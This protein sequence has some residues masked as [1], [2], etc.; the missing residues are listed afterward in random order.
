MQNT[1]SKKKHLDAP[2]IAISGDLACF[3]QIAEYQYV[4]KF[5]RVLEDELHPFGIIYCPGNHDL[6]WSE[7]NGTCKSDYMESL[8]ESP[9]SKTV[10]QIESRFQRPLERRNFKVGMDN[11]Y[12]FLAKI[13][14]HYNNDFLYSIKRFDFNGFPVNFVSLNSAYMFSKDC[15]DFGYIGLTQME[16]AFEELQLTSNGHQS[17]NVALF[18]HPFESIVPASEVETE[19]FL[20]R[21][22]AL[23]LNGHV[24]NL[25]VYYDLTT[26]L[27]GE[28]W[29]RPLISCA[30]CAIDTDKDPYITPGY[31]ILRVDLA[32][33]GVNSIAIY[34]R[35]NH[36][37]EWRE[38]EQVDYPIRVS[39]FSVSPQPKVLN[40]E[41]DMYKEGIR[42]ANSQA[43]QNLIVYQRT[44]S[45]L[46]GAKPYD[47][48]EKDQFELDYI[49][50]LR[51][52][53]ALCV[54]KTG[55]S[56]LYLFDLEKTRKIIKE[57]PE[58]VAFANDKLSELKRLEKESNFRFKFNYV[59]FKF[60]GPLMIG[61]LGYMVWIGSRDVGKEI[62][63]LS[64]NHGAE[65]NDMISALI[66]KFA[67]QPTTTE[68]LRKELGLADTKLS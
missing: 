63:V 40:T 27:T 24:H 60:L 66:S 37:G 44:P 67:V 28:S 15:K 64:S 49:E 14:Q 35:I 39:D 46:L 61:D 9:T 7:Y 55:F 6:N 45:L 11:Y 19:R 36:N 1:L 42:I 65:T 17:F 31:S 34:E 51:E 33:N 18:H 32:Q 52:K 16:K 58:I 54:K 25:K 68:R 22:Y 43:R 21:K 47:Q 10:Q 29:H 20:K 26:N 2:I 62:L 59:P 4:E 38:G 48:K 50:C 5:N 23:F 57:H 12:N 3:G 30:R 41:F 56:M 53:I 8:I 13:G